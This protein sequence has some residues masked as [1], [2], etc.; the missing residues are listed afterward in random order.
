MAALQGTAY[1]EDMATT[2]TEPVKTTLVTEH[3]ARAVAEAA[4]EQDWTAPSFV[5]ELFEGRLR[6]ELIYPYPVTP[7]EEEARAKP[8]LEKLEK[9]LKANVDAE[10]IERD[11]KIPQKV[12][13]GLI[14]LGCMGIKI[15]TEY[16]G[17]GLSQTSYNRAMQ[18]AATAESSI[19]V[20]LSAHQSI[21]V[22]Q[23]LK[24]FGTPEQKKKFLPRLA[25]GAISAFA[26]T[27]PGVGSDPARMTTE[28]V[29]TPEGDAYIINGEKLWCTNGTIAEIM[30]VMA[31][32]GERKISA[33]IV[34]ANWPGVEVVHR[35]SFMGLK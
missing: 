31:K 28:A 13:Q 29:L 21:G 15:P 20:L 35:C 3:E 25:R 7:P 24:I 16:G 9:F 14:D 27:E 32:T 19:G 5:R 2:A 8:F 12:I 33:F 11:E 1:L 6:L 10:Q 22:P 4:R 18:I 34:E 17:L 26:L 30:V 23:P